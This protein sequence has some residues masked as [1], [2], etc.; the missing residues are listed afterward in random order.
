MSRS[1]VKLVFGA[2]ALLGLIGLSLLLGR[3]STR[4]L[5]GS[6]AVTSLIWSPDGRTLA[7]GSEDGIILLWDIPLNRLRQSISVESSVVSL[8]W[9]P[10]GRMLASGIWSDTAGA[11]ITLWDSESGETL[12]SIGVP[13]PR[14]RALSWSPNGLVLSAGLQENMILF[15]DIDSDD[16]QEVLGTD[17]LHL[18]FS[19][20][21][22]LI[23]VGQEDGFVT[24]LDTSSRVPVLSVVYAPDNYVAD[25]AWS[26]DGQALAS[27]SCF[28]EAELPANCTLVLWNPSN[29]KYTASI[30]G[31]ETDFTSIAWS[32]SGKH[33]ASAFLNGDVTL[34]NPNTGS[35]VRTFRTPAGSTLV[36]WAPDGRTLAAGS[37]DGSVL[38]WTIH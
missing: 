14:V 35:R 11:T 18:A 28:S 15:W 34:Y 24:F 20:D 6:A 9:S 12:Q 23:A 30:R 4:T 22:G 5:Q 19:P 36:A 21:G 13:A 37:E 29:E 27:A 3:S 26:P 38:L 7:V 31:G 16:V 32:P 33:I 17:V 25:I 10:D 1:T 2:L 8:A